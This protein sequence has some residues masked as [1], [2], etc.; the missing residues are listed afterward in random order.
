MACDT[1]FRP[2]A[3]RL[4]RLTGLDPA[5]PTMLVGGFC[6]ALT[7]AL[8]LGYLVVPR[9]LVASVEAVV[10]ERAEHPP[11]LAQLALAQL[12]TDGT[13][14][15]LMH[16]RGLVQRHQRAMVVSALAR[17]RPAVMLDGLD[18]AGTVVLRLPGWL[19]A[20][21]VAHGLRREGI[22]LAVVDRHSLLLGYGHLADAALH[23]GLRV[24]VAALMGSLRPR[25][26]AAA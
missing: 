17:L 19:D 25:R 7:P 10:A 3:N 2:A 20:A 18:A 14:V 24:L 9:S 4:P 6:E 11:Y 22:G 12:L 8:G 15:R 26:S 13:V 16:R 21:E 5:A 1:V 23:G